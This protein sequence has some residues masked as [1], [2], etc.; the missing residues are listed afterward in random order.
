VLKAEGIDVTDGI[1]VNVVEKT[2]KQFRASDSE[3]D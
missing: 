3:W 1:T 2:E